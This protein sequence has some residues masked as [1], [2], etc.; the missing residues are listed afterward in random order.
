LPFDLEADGLPLPDGSSEG[1][2]DPPPE[3][4]ELG[5]PV[6]V[7]LGFLLGSEV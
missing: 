3:G 6:G 5:F 4:V 1:S 2:P 7:A